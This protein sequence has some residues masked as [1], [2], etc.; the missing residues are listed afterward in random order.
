MVFATSAILSFFPLLLLSR[1]GALRQDNVHKGLAPQA[2]AP[3]RAHIKKPD[4]VLPD[5]AWL[6]L[7]VSESFPNSE[8]ISKDSPGFR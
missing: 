5:R 2:S 7:A 1:D 4:G 3:W 8:R 6:S